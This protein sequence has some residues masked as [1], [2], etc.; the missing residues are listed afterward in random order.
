MGV[1]KAHYHFK[2]EFS[3]TWNNYDIARGVYLK[4]IQDDVVR[5]LRHSDDFRISASQFRRCRATT[6]TDD[7]DRGSKCGHIVG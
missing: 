7:Y 1:S 6:M 4:T 3:K 5:I 2:C